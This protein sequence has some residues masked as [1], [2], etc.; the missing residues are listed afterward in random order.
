MLIEWL[1]HYLE[2]KSVRKCQD[3]ILPFLIKS[4]SASEQYTLRQIER[5]MI[6]FHVKGLTRQIA[7]AVWVSEADL[8]KFRGFDEVRVRYLKDVYMKYRREIDVSLNTPA[9]Q[10]EYI[11]I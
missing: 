10:N 3:I 4:F 5:A 11:G 6:E 9:K 7:Y 1:R 8:S 2:R